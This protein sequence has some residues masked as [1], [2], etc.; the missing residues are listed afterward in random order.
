MFP[1]GLC[2]AFDRDGR[3]VVAP[4]YDWVGKFYDGR[5]AVRLA[6]LYGYVAAD[7]RE[8]IAPKYPIVG[9]FKHGFAEVD[10]DGKSALIDR[11]GRHVFEPKWGHIEAIG[12]DRFRVSVE[13]R[14]SGPTA[15]KEFG[16]ISISLNADVPGKSTIVLSESG[17]RGIIDRAGAWIEPLGSKPAMDL[18]AADA[19]VKW[20]LVD[21]AGTVVVEPTGDAVLQFERGAA[22][23]NRDK[24]WCAVDRRG[25][26]IFS[27]DCIDR[28]PLGGTTGAFGC[29]PL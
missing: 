23:F 11:E 12:A 3:I 4:H 2:G 7:G 17:T 22:W 1:G 8:V 27:V 21:T 24:Q 25:H 28:K 6:G 15:A 26:R 5:A 20:G 19:S 18:D 9:D 13:R 16:A 10:I 14:I 29:R